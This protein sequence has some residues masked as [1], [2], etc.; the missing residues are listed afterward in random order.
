LINDRLAGRPWHLQLVQL[1]P[2]FHIHGVPLL[3]H[4]GVKYPVPGN[5]IT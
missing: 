2:F 1:G 5:R 3:Y 4:A